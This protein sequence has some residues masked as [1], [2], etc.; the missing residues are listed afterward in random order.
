MYQSNGVGK[1]IL[2]SLHTVVKLLTTFFRNLLK[3][4]N[5]DKVYKVAGC[6]VE[7]S[8]YYFEPIIAEYQEMCDL[9]AKI[10]NDERYK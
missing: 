5:F 3:F 4:R 9:E 1:S 2:G 6:L 10:E 8:N 7:I